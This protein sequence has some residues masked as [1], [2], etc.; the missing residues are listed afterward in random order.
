LQDGA[1]GAFRAA[2]F[3][4]ARHDGKSRVFS[5]GTLAISR[6]GAPREKPHAPARP[7]FNLFHHI[8]DAVQNSRVQHTRA[9]LKKFSPREL[10]NHKYH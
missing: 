9:A 6:F 5:R 2:T 7:F 3:P 1:C 10:P 4:V 8:R